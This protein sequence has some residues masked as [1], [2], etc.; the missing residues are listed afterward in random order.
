MKVEAGEAKDREKMGG[1]INITAGTGSNM[2]EGYGGDV[3][4]QAG[5]S[6]YH[7]KT[8]FGKPHTE[9]N[10]K[11]GGNVQLV[12][13]GTR[14][15]NSGSVLVSSGVSEET[16]SGAVVVTTANSGPKG[17]TGSLTLSTGVS[18]A[19]GSGEIMIQSGDASIKNALPW[20]ERV[21]AGG[22]IHL[23]V[24]TGDYGD[25]TSHQS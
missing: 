19:G 24:G 15:G 5:Y 6:S 21:G 10:T 14:S 18:S 23:K 25:G 4:I 7:V 16:H 3:S 8:G 12:S 22:S 17:E 20:S 9:W 2:F 11:A 1:S 13:G